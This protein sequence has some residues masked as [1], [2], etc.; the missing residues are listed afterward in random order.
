M[1]GSTSHSLQRSITR[2]LSLILFAGSVCASNAGLASAQVQPPNQQ[3]P[4]LSP[5]S[6]PP[7]QS[8][9]SVSL[10]PAV[11]MVRCNFGQSYT[12][13][14]T[15]TNQTDQQFTFEMIAQDVIVRD[16]KRISVPAGET[17]R[18]IAATA[19][20]SQKQVIVA[21]RETA[22]VGVTFTIPPETSLRGAI[23][24]FRG[25]NQISSNGPVKMTAS[26]GSLFTF[27]VS[28][29]IQITGAPVEV[30]AQSPT[31]N[32]R[33][34]QSL[35]NTGS[36][37]IVAHGVAAVLNEAGALVGKTPFDEKRLFP[38]EQLAFAAFYPSELKTGRY[39]V[40]V[41][42]QFDKKILTNSTDF[43]VQ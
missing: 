32:L 33:I 6:S 1:I 29:D 18:G 20:F 13:G 34:S 27:T 17:E 35:T 5:Q 21:P 26:L 4:Q 16:G 8:R 19:V 36:E 14:L 38:G 24:I 37:P 30:T 11:V 3:A 41:S 9:G 2:A 42:F 10:A 31:A 22:T 12:Q 7:P 43:V 15:I 40:L 28:G 39:R 25:L 23:A